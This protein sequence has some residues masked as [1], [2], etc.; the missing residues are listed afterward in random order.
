MAKIPRTAL[1]KEL[2]SYLN[3]K[4]VDV[5]VKEDYEV[6]KHNDTDVIFSKISLA[7]DF[8]GLVFEFITHRLPVKAGNLDA[9]L[10]ITTD[11]A[12]K[13]IK[14][15]QEMLPQLAGFAAHLQNQRHKRRK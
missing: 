4:N 14:E 9:N 10:E 5:F 13:I 6:G 8:S 2:A 15:A 1:F 11:E 3:T 7:Q 12:A